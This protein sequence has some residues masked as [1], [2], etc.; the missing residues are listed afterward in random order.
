M[1]VNSAHFSTFWRFFHQGTSRASF[2]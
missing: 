2:Y 1:I